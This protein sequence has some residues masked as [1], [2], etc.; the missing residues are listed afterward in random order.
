[1]D[2]VYINTICECG[3]GNGFLVR[4]NVEDEERYVTIS[5]TS[6]GFMSKQGGICESIKN[7]IKSAWFM[8]RGKE[9]YLH[10]VVITKKE[11]SKFLSAI[12]T[13]KGEESDGH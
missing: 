12:N 3:C 7:R 6:S 10:D 5:T 1:M 9:Y 11:W 4:I 2:G 13:V 8:L